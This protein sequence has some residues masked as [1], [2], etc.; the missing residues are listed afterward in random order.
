MSSH[1]SA[2]ARLRTWV[3]GSVGLAMALRAAVAAVLAWTVGVPLGGVADDYLYYAPFGAV[4]VVSTT[5]MSS[6]RTSLEVF[7]AIVLGAVVAVG[8]QGLSLPSPWG[9]GAVVL[10]GTLVSRLRWLGASASWV[11]IAGIFV[12]ILGQGHEDAF[13]LGYLG[14]T[15]LGAAVGTAVNL[16]FPPL[17]LDQTARAQDA[18]RLALVGQ[19]DHLADGLEEGTLP[20]AATAGAVAGD[21]LVH[22]RAVEDLVGQALDG[23]PVNWR[24][25]RWRGQVDELRRHGAALVSLALLVRDL[26]HTLHRRGDADEEATVLP[27]ALHAPAARALRAAARALSDGAAQSEDTFTEAHRRV[28]DLVDAIHGVRREQEDDLFVAGAL[29]LGLRSALEAA[30]VDPTVTALPDG[31]DD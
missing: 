5:V 28:D 26:T 30:Q 13:V 27:A 7:L 23:P 10:I 17:L 31:R 8:V 11:P 1:R 3:T 22:G 15:T 19:L 4:V 18:L 12:L 2:A 24:V 21:L 25:R 16:A 20:D 9:I 14:L 6:V 29:V